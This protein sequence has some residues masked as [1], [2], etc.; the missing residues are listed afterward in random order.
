MKQVVY[1]ATPESKQ[2]HVWSIDKKGKLILLQ[3]LILPGEVQPMQIS[4]D[5]RQLYVGI[6]P[7]FG[8]I[9]YLISPEGKIKQQAITAIPGNPTHIE[10]DKLGRW[11]FISSYHQ[12]NLM[13]LPIDQRGV[14]QSAIQVIYDLKHP[15]S[16]GVNFDNSRLFV[17]CLGEDH[18]RIYAINN[19]GYLTEHIAQRIKTNKG[20][21]PRHLTFLPNQNVFYCLN[22]LDATINVYSAFEPYK[23][24]QN[25][26]ILPAV[27]ECKPWAADIHITPNGR[28]LYA[29]ERSSSIIRHFKVTA[30]G[31]K[32]LPM[33]S[34]KTETQPRGFDIDQSGNFLLAAGQKSNY[35]VVYKINAVT[36][37]L[38]TLDRYAVNTGPIWITT[39]SI[40]N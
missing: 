18:I 30:E 37:A 39:H 13:V 20:A 10:I 1:V 2:I 15:H 21:G 19:N 26:N 28:H 3:Q 5:G 36:G 31:L 7:N 17:P 35:I 14:A 4:R 38:Q 6:H 34:Y 29:S 40:K 16:S 32:L 12:G 22:E 33:M 24:M 9:T 8:I 27:S 25:C 23:Q 11:L